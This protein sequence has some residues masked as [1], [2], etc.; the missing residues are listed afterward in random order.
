MR[1]WVALGVSVMALMAAGPAWAS[2]DSLSLSVAPG[3]NDTPNGLSETATWSL[4][5]P[6]DTYILD[7]HY[8]QAAPV[9]RIQPTTPT[10]SR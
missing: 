6:S 8:Q 5:N 7:A 3:A 10:R 9:P 2:T 1:R 4:G